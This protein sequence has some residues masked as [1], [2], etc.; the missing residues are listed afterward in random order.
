M[1]LPGGRGLFSQ[2][3][4]VLTYDSNPQ[5]AD[6]LRLTTAVHDQLDDFRWLASTIT[7]RPTRWGELVDSSPVYRGAV[8]ASGL[9]MGGVWLHTEDAAPPLL[10]RVQFPNA[11]VSRL[12]S[13]DR[14]DGDLTNSDLEQMGTICHQD[15]LVHC[16]DVRELTICSLTDNTAALSRETHGSTSVDAPSAYLCRLSALH[17]R[18]YRYRLRLAYIP[19]PSNVMADCL[20]RRWD[21][22]DDTLLA[23][24]ATHFPQVHPW[25]ICHLRP[26]MLSAATSSLSK[27]RCDPASLLAET[28]P[29]PLTNGNGRCSVNNTSWTVTSAVGQI[30]YHGSKFSA[31]AS[32]AGTTPPAVNVSDLAQWETPSSWY[33]RRSPAWVVLTPD[34]SLVPLPS[35]PDSNDSSGA[36]PKTMHHQSG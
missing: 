28:Q 22:D 23:H 27:Q 11:I 9:G 6:R 14:P 30:Q 5:P 20:S 24:F 1:A 21:F 32:E 18:A 13:A 8:D 15:I 10:W 7:S 36:M 31:F 17:Q 3:Q 19:G 26:N 25:Q 16:Y 12:V 4:S 34:T 33:H 2:L 35:T 29:L